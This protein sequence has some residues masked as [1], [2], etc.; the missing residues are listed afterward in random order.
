[1]SQHKIALVV[2]SLIGAS[3]VFGAAAPA[4]AATCGSSQ[5]LNGGFEAV[6]INGLVSLVNTSVVDPNHTSNIIDKN[7]PIYYSPN[8]QGGVN[9][10]LVWGYWYNHL[11]PYFAQVKTLPELDHAN[12]PVTAT[13]SNSTATTLAWSTTEGGIDL[14]QNSPMFGTVGAATTPAAHSGSQWAE[15]SGLVATNTL[16][17]T[18]TTVPGTVMTWSLYH[19]GYNTPSVGA[20]NRDVMQVQIGPPTATP[21]TPGQSPST[22][23]VS[24]PATPESV[25]AGDPT[26]PTHISDTKDAWRKWSGTYTVP[27]GQTQTIFAFHGVSAVNN[28]L[29]S[30]NEIDDISFSCDQALSSALAAQTAPSVATVDNSSPNLASTGLNNDQQVSL[31]EIG[32]ISF[33]VGISVYFGNIAYRRRK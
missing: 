2:S 16:Y 18:V 28:T 32:A 11:S 4:Q 8:W 24:Q 12:N 27:A 9:P 26:D 5:I 14:M 20:T 31:A 1:L 22:A 30:G 29:D 19:R 13:S 33:F 21:N 15:I 23:L 25:Q 6:P 3:F 10:S 17:Q 7:G